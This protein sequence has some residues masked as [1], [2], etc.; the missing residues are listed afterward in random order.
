MKYLRACIALVVIMTTVL[1]LAAESSEYSPKDAR[2]RIMASAM[3]SC[4]A[5]RPSTYDQRIE[6]HRRFCA[7]AVAYTVQKLSDRGVSD[8]ERNGGCADDEC[9]R[10]ID[11]GFMTCKNELHK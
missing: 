7:C 8:Y 10:A 1:S 2:S 3:Q 6:N 11:E 9:M 5:N 4:I